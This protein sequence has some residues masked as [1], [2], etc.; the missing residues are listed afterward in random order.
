MAFGDTTDPARTRRIFAAAV[1]FV[2]AMRLPEDG[3]TRLA[4]W[5]EQQTAALA[6]LVAAVEQDVVQKEATDATDS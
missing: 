2:A 4:D 3:N 6:A 5:Q 1:E